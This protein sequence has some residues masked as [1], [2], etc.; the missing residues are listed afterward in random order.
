VFVMNTRRIFRSTRWRSILAVMTVLLVFVA[1]SSFCAESGLSGEDVRKRDLP[2][3]AT[4]ISFDMETRS[5]KGTTTITFHD[6]RDAVIRLG[7]LSVRSVIYNGKPLETSTAGGKLA[8][9]TEEGDILRIEYEC[10]GQNSSC[11]IGEKGIF[12]SGGWYPQMEG[13]SYQRLQ[14]VVP[15]NFTALSEADEIEKKKD[16]RGNHFLFRF[17]HPVEG[18]NFIAGSF[19]EKKERFRGTELYA[20]FFPEDRKLARGYLEH[21]K[22]YL[23]FYEKMIGRFPYRRFSV[24]ENFLPAGYSV[25]TLTLLGQDVV[26]LPF[27]V[28]TSLGHEILHQWLGDFVYVDYKKGNWSEGLTTYLSDYLYEDQKGRGLEYR[29]QTLV[30]YESY[31]GPRN[32][33][34]LSEFRSRTDFAS[35]AIGYGKSMMVFH[36]LRELVGKETFY[37]AI[38][39]F[40]EE[41]RFIEASWD[42]IKS[43]FESE[44][45]KD[46]GWFFKQWV[47]RKGLPSVNIANVTIEPKGLLYSLTFDLVQGDQ[48]YTFDLHAA[49]KTDGGETD[50]VLKVKDKKQHV[51]ILTEENPRRLVLDENYEIFR[52]MDPDEAPPVIAKLLGD[53]K[54]V[55]VLDGKGVSADQDESP[56]SGVIEFFRSRGYEVKKPEEVKDEEVSASNMVLLGYENTLAKRFFAGVKGPSQGFA[57]IMKKNPFRRSRVVGVVNS[58]SRAET[59]AAIGKISHYGKYSSVAFKGGKN[60]E[61]KIDEGERGLIMFLTEPVF[62][63]EVPEALKLADI[64]DKVSHKK[65]VYVGEQHDRYQHHMTEF[66]VIKTL[67]KKNHKIAIGMEMFQRPFQK[68]L[69]DYVA[70]RVDERQFLKSS[71]YFK[72]WVFDYNLYKDIL[73]FA[74]SEKIPVVA[75]NIRNEIVDKISRG[76]IDSLTEKEKKELPDTMD[77]SDEDYRDR[78]R[79]V[80][81]GHKGF[82][83]RDFNHFFQAQ[84]VWDETMAQSIADYVKRNPDRQM[85]VVAGGGHL[86]FSSGIPNRV[87]RRNGLDHS[88]ILNDQ[89]VE[90]NVADF[91]LFPGPVEMVSTPQLM[92]FLNEYHGRLEVAGFPKGSIAEKAGLKKGD[93]IVSIDGEKIKGIDDLKIFLFYKKQGDTVKITVLRKR[94]LFGK[95]EL[96]FDVTL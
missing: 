36:M 3:Y 31:V 44:S 60:T 58:S 74:R 7:S 39:H 29:K 42:D 67:F 89:S 65:I 26:R 24:V 18:I 92:V 59:E 93:I 15:G 9:K 47:E 62:G 23:E 76:G 77:M 81:A 11:A 33:F 82:G 72:R 2:E 96:S 85:V 71:E 90:P 66:E 49:V 61:K 68:V 56:Y 86:M 35:K 53:E 70:G 38:R 1:R 32:D 73:R 51:E 55:L 12:L 83:E 40:V 80:F 6:R 8:I 41:N 48:N 17:P 91:V 75:L 30:D 27:I 34:P 10:S 78:L 21:T 45:G 46:L 95:K 14:A 25:P 64:I 43:V 28:K 5:M 19:V 84:I 22:K 87:F 94:F 50:S 52:K 4:S 63:V 69:D 54:G 57:L 37:K 88:I 13:L 79:S 16:P 20:Y